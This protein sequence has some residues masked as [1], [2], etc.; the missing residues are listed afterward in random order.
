MKVVLAI[1]LGTTG[2]RVIAFSE[3][4]TIVAKSC[5]EFPQIFPKPGW[6]EHNP[7]DILD[8]TKKA[9]KDVISSVGIDS[10]VS[11]GITNQRET[12]IL[13]DR[14]TGRPVY[15][16]IVWQCRRTKEIC[17][18]LAEYSHIIREKTGLPLDPYFSATKIKWIIENIEGVREQ[19]DKGNIL[20]GTVDRIFT[21]K[22]DKD[23]D[24]GNS[25]Y[26]QW[27]DAVKRAMNWVE[28]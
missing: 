6:V 21:P 28:D 10:V 14:K 13:W 1:D 19:I 15:N 7:F 4:G 3:D 20:F 22:M 8:T 5:Y 9:L 11:I 26:S 24:K 25:Y 17:D 27:K 12:T 2:N 18:R 16:A 23:K